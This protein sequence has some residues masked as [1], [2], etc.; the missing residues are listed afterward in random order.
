MGLPIDQ[1]THGHFVGAI[2]DPTTNQPL[3]ASGVTTD[4]QAAL[5]AAS[6]LS[7][8][9]R[10]AAASDLVVSS[11][12]SFPATP[13]TGLFYRTDRD[14]VYFHD[15]TRWLTAN[16]YR[17]VFPGGETVNP[18]SSNKS[19]GFLVPWGA[20]DIWM[21]T[22]YSAMFVLTTNNGTNF[23]TVGLN[24]DSTNGTQTTFA[25]FTT[26]AD[27]ANAWVTRATA[28]GELFGGTAKLLSVT[29]SK[30][31]NP[32]NLYFS[33]ALSYRLVG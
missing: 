30:T 28:V 2:I 9:D 24:R 5:D 4:Q 16:L 29:A 33:N 32:G 21:E 15:G 19:L 7:G 22:W 23:W 8:S 12:T 27:A 11:G 6:S 10:V 3:A 13:F 31:L 20:T 26:A 1:V 14:L 25:S 17:D 18:A